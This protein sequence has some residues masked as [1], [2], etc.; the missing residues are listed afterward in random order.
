MLLCRPTTRTVRLCGRLALPIVVVAVSTACA[1]GSR[2]APSGDPTLTAN[3]IV[4]GRTELISALARLPE[5]S[6][7]VTNEGS[8]TRVEFHI[9][10][11][12]EVA[13]WRTPVATATPTPHLP[14]RAVIEELGPPEFAHGGF[15]VEG[16]FICQVVTLDYPRRGLRIV[17]Y[18]C[19]TQLMDM[20]GLANLARTALS[21]NEET[22][23]LRI[24]YYPAVSFEKA[25]RDVYRCSEA[26]VKCIVAG[27]A[28]QGLDRVAQ[29]S[30][31]NCP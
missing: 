25:L 18:T 17:G 21:V 5:D 13:L 1:A 6:F 30:A 20:A 19:E 27:S 22:P 29:V 26:N 11:P 31:C 24:D 28:W 23:V 12:D 15:T 3:R 2:S 4:P 9:Y 7:S 14:L 8:L 16:T 10:A